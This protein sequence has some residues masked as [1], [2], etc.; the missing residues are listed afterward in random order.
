MQLHWEES[1]RAACPPIWTVAEPGDHGAEVT[2]T[3]GIGVK[4][5]NAAA[6]A[7]AT[8]GL[9]IE[10]HMPKGR[11]LRIGLLSIT[12]ASGMVVTALFNGSTFNID[13]ATPKGQL[14]TAPPQTQKPILCPRTKPSTKRK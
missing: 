13:G 9:E 1:V 12:V 2:G 11:I 8:V 14:S 3:Q 4:T 7:A 5:P 10:L 6:V